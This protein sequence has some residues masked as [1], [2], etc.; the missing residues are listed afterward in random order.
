M[1]LFRVEL[2]TVL[3]LLNKKYIPLLVLSLNEEPE[4]AF[5]E[6]LTINAP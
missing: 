6:P 3:P 1:L 2:E 4:N 5:P